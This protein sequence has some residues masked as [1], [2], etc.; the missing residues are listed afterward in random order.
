MKLTKETKK[1]MEE[2]EKLAIL[3]VLHYGGIHKKARF[4]SDYETFTYGGVPIDLNKTRKAKKDIETNGIDWELS[5]TVEDSCINKFKGTLE[6]SGELSI[7]STYIMSKSGICY[8]FI[9]GIGMNSLKSVI[10][11]MDSLKESPLLK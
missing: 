7:Y 1:S 10:E 2:S 9:C 6:E 8:K 3:Y 4:G 11:I 5:T